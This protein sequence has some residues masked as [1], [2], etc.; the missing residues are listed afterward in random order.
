VDEAAREVR[1]GGDEIPLTRTEFDLLVALSEHPAHV[2]TRGQLASHIFGGV[3]EESDRT[4]D[5]HIRNLRHKLGPRPE[6][7]EYVE[8]VRGV[9]YRIARE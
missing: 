4:V 9:G 8:T 7:G 2:L 3:Y 6:G 1:R 5:S